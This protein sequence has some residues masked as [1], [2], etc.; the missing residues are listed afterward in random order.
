MPEAL[1]Y[2]IRPIPMTGKLIEAID[3][4]VIGENF[5]ELKNL[6]PTETHKRAVAGMTKITTAALSFEDT[7]SRAAKIRNAIHFVKEEPYESHIVVEAY[8]Y[9]EN[10][11]RLYTLD[12]TVPNTDTFGTMLY[13]VAEKWTAATAIT[14][15][16][17][18]FPTT[19]NGYH[20][21][22]IKAGTTHGTTE[23]TWPTTPL[24]TVVD[25]SA[26]VWI[27][28]EGSLHGAFSRTTDGSLVYANSAKILIWP[29]TEHK[30]GAVVNASAA[31]FPMPDMDD[32][33]D[34]T[35]HLQNTFTDDKNVAIVTGL[36]YSSVGVYNAE[37]Y[38]GSPYR[39][40]GAKFYVQNP[41]GYTPAT[42]SCETAYWANGGM[43]TVL[44][45]DGTKTGTNTLTQTGSVTFSSDT[46]ALVQPALIFGRMLYWYRFRFK[47]VPASGT[48]RPVL[49]FVTIDAP[50]QPLTNI[51]D[52]TPVPLLAV[53]KNPSTDKYIDYTTTVAEQDNVKVYISGWRSNPTLAMN[54][55]GFKATDSMYF[56]CAVRLT[57]LQ[58]TMSQDDRNR[59]AAIIRVEYFN[60]TAWVACADVRDGTSLDG[61]SL[62]QSGTVTWTPPDP[63]IEFKTCVH[64]DIELFYYRV[65][66]SAVLSDTDVWVDKVVGIPMPVA[67]TGSTGAFVAQDRLFLVKE[68]TLECSPVGR[69]SVINGSEHV[70]FA[71]GDESRITGGCHLFSIQ[72][73][74]YYSPI[75]IFKKTA[76][77]L[78]TGT[79]PDW[80][81]HELSRYDGLAAP[82]TLVVV[83]LPISIPGFG[84]TVAIGQG[85]TGIFISD[86][87][88]PRIV[89]KDIEQYFDPRHEDCI[90]PENLDK[91]V[92]F[93]DYDL[94]E[95][96]WLFMSGTTETRKEMVLNLHKMEWFEID[97]G[98]H[99]LEFGFSVMDSW[100]K[101]YTYGTCSDAY[102]KRLEYGTTFDGDPI[103]CT[104]WPGDVALSGDPTI[105]TKCE[106][107]Q[108]L[109][110]AKEVT[111]A[112]VAY[113][114]YLD[115]NVAAMNR[116]I[117][118]TPTADGKRVANMIA[119]VKSPYAVF[120]SGK[121][122]FSCS[123]EDVAF[124]PLAWMY[125]YEI[126]HQR[127]KPNQSDTASPRSWL[128]NEGD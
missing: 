30:A 126:E 111:S 120:H 7:Q 19:Y 73:S 125:H 45:T 79:G 62:W 121:A 95:Y 1:P 97:R 37:V 113:D 44:N 110:V 14:K 58:V 38:I 112:D 41:V 96:H 52:G 43:Q 122:S 46:T 54:L 13:S 88:P 6:R 36:T 119:K 64:N 78:L 101:Q 23:P 124:E 25:N 5:R 86:G 71:M 4:V 107:V 53:W 51:W 72:G 117:T 115:T 81:R 9:A 85:A 69:P 109:C 83:N 56:G 61:K 29:G 87:R 28:R 89:S 127:V 63:S 114:H 35:D 22:C 98:N 94:L 92:G 99:P 93:M 15:G 84:T 100:R 90:Q 8:N 76:T 66:W 21:E 26:V 17:I 42:T 77:F 74:E 106:Q 59:R 65:Y 70:E 33:F 55:S 67:L 80:K 2:K 27:C 82:D 50:M 57:G 3:P 68:N 128:Y 40:N 116:D 18:V 47:N 20:Y 39:I 104:M 16:T 49:Y 105:E 60:G 48:S 108:I 32:M 118:L 31:A 34:F 11:L 123:D 12:G 10:S 102:V 91:S 24:S 103:V 75:L